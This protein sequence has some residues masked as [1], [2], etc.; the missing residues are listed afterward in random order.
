MKVTFNRNVKHNGRLYEAGHTY[1]FEGEMTP[2]LEKLLDTT[3]TDVF[4]QTREG[5]EAHA[6]EVKVAEVAPEAAQAEAQPAPAEKTP[7]INNPMMPPTP[8]V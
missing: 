4:T 2:E 3:H 5:E 7:R 6:E 1:E 8:N